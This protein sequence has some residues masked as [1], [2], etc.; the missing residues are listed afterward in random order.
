VESFL[1]LQEM[2]EGEAAMTSGTLQQLSEEDE[3]GAVLALQRL[4]PR[5]MMHEDRF[6]INHGTCQYK[7]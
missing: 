5:L 7:K 2:D 6:V 3:E 4:G 1:R